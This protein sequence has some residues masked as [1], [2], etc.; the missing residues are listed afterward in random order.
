MRGLLSSPHRRCAEGTCGC[1]RLDKRFAASP[2]FVS[3]S[4]T[5]STNMAGCDNASTETD[6]NTGHSSSTP[7][8]E[9]TGEIPWSV[10]KAWFTDKHP[11]L[12]PKQQP[13]PQLPQRRVKDSTP[14]SLLSMNLSNLSVNQ[15]C[16]LETMVSVEKARR[17]DRVAREYSEILRLMRDMESAIE[18]MSDVSMRTVLADAA[19]AMKQVITTLP[20][21]A[22]VLDARSRIPRWSTSNP[23]VDPPAPAVADEIVAAAK[24]S[25]PS[26]DPSSNPRYIST[27]T[28]DPAPDSHTVIGAILDAATV[29]T[30]DDLSQFFTKKP[31]TYATQP[32]PDIVVKKPRKSGCPPLYGKFRKCNGGMSI[33]VD[34]WETDTPSPRVRANGTHSYSVEYFFRK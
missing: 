1:V 32:S 15:L 14:T 33:L 34:W 21:I 10:A 8:L 26:P 29:P 31:W 6:K 11:A 27:P 30:H 28:P 19:A 18:A 22:A 7:L 9:D 17:V 4:C 20:G 24:P 16:D 13:Q 23:L 5:R 2:S 25:S 3:V 12:E